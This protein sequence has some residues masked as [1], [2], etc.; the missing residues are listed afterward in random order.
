[1]TVRK[2]RERDFPERTQGMIRY[3]CRKCGIDNAEAECRQCGK[4]L[5]AA[6]MRDIW[7]VYRIP[8]TDLGAWKS[9]FLILLCCAAAVLLL[10]LVWETA[11]GGLNAALRLFSGG[12]ALRLA[13]I[14]PAGLAAVLLFRALQGRETLVFSLDA[15]GAHMQTWHDAGRLKSWA[16]LQRAHQEDAAEQ[17]DGSLLLQSQTRHL[18]WS[19]VKRLL[20]QPDRG[21][22]RLF[23]ARHAA[24]MVLRLPP[25]EYDNAE[26]L[27][28][29]YCKKLLNT[30]A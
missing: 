12:L 22:I 8:L 20:F 28:K 1:M 13:L 25:E 27:V 17:Q 21:E 10:I 2:K 9:A 23:H 26:L 11:A 24:P 15:Q 18:L 7:R 16:R 5:P 14:V 3:Y 4:K 19:D 30:K 6:V 29:K